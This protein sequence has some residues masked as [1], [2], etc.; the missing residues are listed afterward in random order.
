[1]LRD[2]SVDKWYEGTTFRVVPW[3]RTEKRGCTKKCEALERCER[4]N[5]NT[6]FER[7]LPKSRPFTLKF[8]P[9]TRKAL[10]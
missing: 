1:M 8:R 9:S 2:A 5:E 3:V 10:R 7:A 4:L 6:R